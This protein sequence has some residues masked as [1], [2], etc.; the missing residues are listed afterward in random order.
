MSIMFV[1][2]LLYGG[3]WCGLEAGGGDITT[4]KLQNFKLSMIFLVGF[5]IFIGFS[6]V[7]N[8]WTWW[9]S[10]FLVSIVLHFGKNA[11]NVWLILG[12]LHQILLCWRQHFR[13]SRFSK[14]LEADDG[15]YDTLK[16][17]NG[18]DQG[19]DQL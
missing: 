7:C 2:L 17:I 3:E 10:V 19:A 4:K 15:G 8:W 6:A 13:M 11:Q 16:R 5:W 1:V 14:S 9:T 18:A 12:C